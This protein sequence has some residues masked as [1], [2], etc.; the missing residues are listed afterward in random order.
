M[1]SV[2]NEFSY[3][4]SLLVS[5]DPS[6]P[7]DLVLT[8]LHNELW[9]SWKAGLGAWDGYVLK[10]SGPV[11]DTTTLGPEECDAVFPGPLPPGQYTLR[12][13]VVAGPYDAWV[14]ASSWLGGESDWSRTQAGSLCR[15]I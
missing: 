10:L 3:P 13:K 8:P 6:Y 9:A 15:G 2:Q 7:S 5:S 4:P 14:E 1:A 12:L 11:E